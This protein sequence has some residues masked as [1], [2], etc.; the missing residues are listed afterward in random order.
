M[1]LRGL[2]IY[3]LALELHVFTSQTAHSYRLVGIIF[4]I[5]S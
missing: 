1:E 4:V 5:V 2:R 3:N